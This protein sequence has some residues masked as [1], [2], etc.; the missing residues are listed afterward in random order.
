[1]TKSSP[2][3]TG[4]ADPYTAITWEWERLASRP[5]AR[6]S[7]DRWCRTSSRFVGF[8]SPLALVAAIGQSADAER[9]QALLTELI[10]LAIGDQLAQFAVL[11]AVLP[12]VRTTAARRW[13]LARADGLWHERQELDADAIAAA[14]LA[15]RNAVGR[16]HTR[17]ALVVVRRVERQL[18]TVHQAHRRSAH[19]T[20][21][22]PHDLALAQPNGGEQG[23]SGQAAALLVGA[24]RAHRLDLLDA[25]IVYQVAVAGLSLTA[26][27]KK[28]GVKRSVARRSLVLGRKVMGS[29]Q[30][31]PAVTARKDIPVMPMNNGSAVLPLLLNVQ[32]AAQLIGIGRTTVYK[33]MDSGEL[34]FVHVGA[35]RRVPL[36]AAYD[37]VDRLC[38]GGHRPAEAN[39]QAEPAAGHLRLARPDPPGPAPGEGK[40]RA[41]GPTD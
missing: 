5:E 23:A 31:L 1:M 22:L 12:A 14:W 29:R 16:R 10:A 35:S 33:L 32:Q 19:A 18:R 21:P 26:T 27:A 36:Q 3:A 11:M 25:A 41:I 2:S 7:L 20:V 17:P 9:A 39:S 40:H 34:F 8:S 28:V 24:V 15:I 30:T 6:A 37:Y 38:E 4:S 13:K